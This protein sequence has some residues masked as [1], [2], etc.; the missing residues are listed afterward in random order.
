[1]SNAQ[2]AA[3]LKAELAIVSPEVKQDHQPNQQVQPTQPKKISFLDKVFPSRRDDAWLPDPNLPSPLDMYIEDE[4][5][6]D[7]ARIVFMTNLLGKLW[8]R[9]P[10][11]GESNPPSL[12]NK[13]S[14][15]KLLQESEDKESKDPCG[16]PFS[17]HEEGQGS[18]NASVHGGEGKQKSAT[19]A[20]S[21]CIVFH[22]CYKTGSWHSGFYCF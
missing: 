22:F 13:L 11:R 20:S 1:M 6:G 4:G 2:K 14:Q 12:F 10:S 3:W 18:A 7:A 17:Q 15:M 21:F 19:Q 16:A 8:P 9:G 5:Q